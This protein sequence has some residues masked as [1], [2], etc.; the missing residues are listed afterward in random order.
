MTETYLTSEQAKDFL[1]K[2]PTVQWI[3]IFMHDLNGI[4]R[5]KRI[6]SRDLLGFADKGFMVP[7]TCYIMDMRGSCVEETGRLWETGDPGSAVPHSL[8]R[9]SCPSPSK[10]RRTRRR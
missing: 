9:R 10:A 1:A 4:P 7:S 2:Y 3:D 5:G 6:R 8:P